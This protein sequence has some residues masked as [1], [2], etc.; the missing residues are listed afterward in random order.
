MKDNFSTQAAQYA[1]FR[2]AYPAALYDFLLAQTPG[3]SAVW[4]AATGNGQVAA[5]LVGIF[6]RVYATDISARQLEQAVPHPDI[7]YAVGA[8]EQTDFPDAAFDL[9]TAAQAAHWFDFD[10]FY[11]EVKRVLKTGG[12][13]ALWGYG[14]LRTEDAAVDRWLDHF[15]REVV[16][17]YWDA[18]RRHV[19]AAYRTL[20]FPL[21]ELAAPAFDMPYHWQGGHFAGYLG[22]WSAVQ[23][24]RKARGEDPVAARADELNDLWPADKMLEVRFPVFLRAGRFV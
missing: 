3:R 24:Y 2:P 4:D 23:H 12:L 20:P 17:P 1:R 19:D 13:L 18:E 15:Y 5:A 14:L 6:A 21:E 10:R 7:R 16:G 9:V 11:P 22:T 8:A